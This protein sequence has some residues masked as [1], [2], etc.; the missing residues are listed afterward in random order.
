[1]STVD[2]LQTTLAAEHAAVWLYGV[3]G[4]QTSASAEAALHALLTQTYALHRSRRDELTRVLRDL[5]EEP[6]AAAPSYRTSGELRTP[7]E[8]RAAAL[9]VEDACATTYADL[10]AN[11]VQDQR[12]WAVT[13]LVDAAV[14]R[15]RFGGA[16][17]ELPG[18]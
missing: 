7:D 11:S 16:P 2:S 18:G 1:M 14:R 17:E 13:A 3:L 6:V 12:R 15:V 8:R 10:V 5:G 4:G 9:E